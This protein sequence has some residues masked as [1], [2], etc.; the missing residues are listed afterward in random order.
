MGNQLAH[1]VFV[2]P[3]SAQR[4]VQA[5]LTATVRRLQTQVDWRREDTGREDGISE[6]KES[7]SARRSKHS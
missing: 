6:L 7:A 4:S 3:S 5:A 2:D 1:G